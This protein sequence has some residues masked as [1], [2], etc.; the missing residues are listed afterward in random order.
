MLEF[1]SLTQ[2]EL[3]LYFL[4]FIFASILT[5]LIPGLVIFNFKSNKLEYFYQ[6]VI[7]ITLGMVIFALVAYLTAWLGVSWL[8]IPYLLGCFYLFLRQKLWQKLLPKDKS[9]KILNKLSWFII[10]VGSLLQLSSVIGSGL[11]YDNGLRF[12]WLN[13]ADGIFHLSLIES[14][15]EKVPP[16]QP[17]AFDLTVSNYHYL[18]NLLIAEFTK[19][20]HL[21]ISSTFFQ[22]LPILLAPLFGFTVA[23][24]LYNWQA[25]QA[26]I[27]W[28]LF[29]LYFSA[30]S[31]WIFSYLLNK[32]F[33][34]G[35][36]TIDSGIIQFLNM[37]QAMAKLSFF[38]GL[39]LFTLYRKEKNPYF[40][41]LSTIL[42]I[43]LVS[44]KIYFGIFIALSYVLFLIYR[45]LR[46]KLKIKTF[47]Q[48]EKY[49]IGFIIL[50]AIGSAILFFPT[51]SGAGGLFW[52]PLDWPKLFITQ[53]GWRDWL[54]RMQVYEA[55][56]NVK[57]I[58]FLELVAM[59]VFLISIFGVRLVGLLSF[60][61]TFRKKI[62]EDVHVLIYPA[63]IILIFLG[64]N[65][66][67]SSGGHNVFNFFVV[68]LS[69]L[70]LLTAI[71]LGNMRLN[72]FWIALI[73]AFT[74]PRTGYTFYSYLR[75]CYLGYDYVLLSNQRLEAYQFLEQNYQNKII[76]GHTNSSLVRE[77]PELWMFTRQRAYLDGIGILQSHN[78]NI[79]EKELIINDIFK[80]PDATVSAQALLKSEIDL[81]LIDK[82]KGEKINLLTPFYN[83][84]IKIWQ[85][86]PLL[87]KSKI[88]FE[89]EEIR[90]YEIDKQAIK[91]F[92][93]AN[94]I[95]IQN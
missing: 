53:S 34:W 65:T 1:F 31:S 19:L 92:L 86:D 26:V 93:T 42:F 66:L 49:S 14:I 50:L 73:L 33:D 10:I 82:T 60:L 54:L 4:Y 7:G 17:G 13:G 37:P 72:F 58:V 61:K 80:A 3:Y 81:I 30:D 32:K 47:L 56:H 48:E 25:K 89:N 39:L 55:Y 67:Q 62:N 78:Q 41:L 75:N 94:L 71:V 91:D 90:V 27:N 15:I 8:L 9:S 57:A 35:I 51:N 84:I 74:L 68:A 44:F 79:K 52:A 29:L 23:V 43:S 24:L 87:A 21:P 28:G 83:E 38:V 59:A 69:I 63:S 76:Q 88:T 2:P 5:F 36:S 40:G 85:I 95:T 64:M 46:N 12:Y 22:Y 6:W 11:R 70:T 20:W 77:T 16:M 45:L 18:S